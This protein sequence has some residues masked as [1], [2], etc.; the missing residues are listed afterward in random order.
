M[1]YYYSIV[2]QSVMPEINRC[3]IKS[4]YHSIEWTT[5]CIIVCIGVNMVLHVARNKCMTTLWYQ[6]SLLPFVSI[7]TPS[8]F[9][10]FML[11]LFRPKLHACLSQRV[12]TFC[13]VRLYKVWKFAME[14]NTNIQTSSQN[15]PT[16]WKWLNKK[17]V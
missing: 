16:Q 17:A 1:C 7:K 11:S 4:L 15:K 14:T 13:C 5:K 10:C 3:L 12:P 8:V 2:I 6:M 9:V